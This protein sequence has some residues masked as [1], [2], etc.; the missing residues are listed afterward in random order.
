LKTCNV[1]DLQQFP[2][3]KDHD[4]AKGINSHFADL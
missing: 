2:K 1:V 3:T 4:G